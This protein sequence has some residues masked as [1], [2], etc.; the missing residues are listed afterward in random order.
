MTAPDVAV[1]GGGIV[2]CALAAFLAEGGARVVLYEREAIAAGASGRNSGVV[3]HTLDAALSSLYE[4]SLEHYRTLGHGFE[5]PAEPAGLLLVSD[6][7]ETL[8]APPAE[9]A[10]L[11]PTFLEGAALKAA[12]PALADGLAAYRLETG[13]PVPPAAAASAFAARARAAGADLR[14]GAAAHVAIEDGRAAGV[15]VG[16]ELHAA[17]AVVVAAG[18]WTP[19]AITGDAAR[20]VPI[21]PLWGVVVELELA[22]PPR[23]V[24]EE[25]GIDVLT[26]EAGAPATLFSAVTARGISAVGST[27][28]PERPDPAALAPGVLARGARFLPGLT[29]GRVLGLRACARPSSADGRPMLGLLPGVE[30]LA[31]ASGHGPWG[32]TLGPASAR[33]VAD[34]LLRH[35]AEIP[36]ALSAG[37]F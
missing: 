16:G 29:S 22:A 7:P 10:D 14:I 1:I 32:I 35:A 15:T 20:R 28:L 31:V 18:P 23:H 21:A 8:E 25:A 2:G 26:S 11:R 3:Q 36:P 37:R 6:H 17:G 33:L 5:L 13:H 30:G 4:E 12:E 27:F 9:F 19:E 24:L 34:Q